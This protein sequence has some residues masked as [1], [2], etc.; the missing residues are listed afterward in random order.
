MHAGRLFILV[1]QYLDQR[2]AGAP[3]WRRAA[4]G[5][6]TALG[7]ALIA[8]GLLTLHIGLIVA[9]AI[10]I[11]LTVR[12]GAAAIRHRLGGRA[13]APPSVRAEIPAETAR[14]EPASVPDS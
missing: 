7:L 4:A 5:L 12:Q 13:E 6:G 1:K 2:L 8:A 11:V 3:A 9:G 14:T 10:L